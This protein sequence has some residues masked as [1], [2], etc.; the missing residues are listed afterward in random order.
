MYAKTPENGFPKNRSVPVIYFTDIGDPDEVIDMCQNYSE[1]KSDFG[2]EK[3]AASRNITSNK[4]E[5][6]SLDVVF[7]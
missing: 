3:T 4:S 6:P 5:C 7:P 2:M 1:K